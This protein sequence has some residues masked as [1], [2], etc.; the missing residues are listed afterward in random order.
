MNV[1]TNVTTFTWRLRYKATGILWLTDTKRFNIR[2]FNNRVLLRCH[3]HLFARKVLILHLLCEKS[4]AL[5]NDGELVQI[6]PK[7]LVGH[8]GCWKIWFGHKMAE[9][10][11]R[12]IE[13]HGNRFWTSC[14]HI[15]IGFE[16]HRQFTGKACHHVDTWCLQTLQT[17]FFF[18]L[19]LEALCELKTRVTLRFPLL[20]MQNLLA[21]PWL[22][23]NE[24]V[25]LVFDCTWHLNI[26]KK[27]P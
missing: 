11:K 27:K 15:C 6:P 3:F 22:F 23:L 17:L 4:G 10:Q 16:D 8:M 9:T 26:G 24:E 13:K 19:F 20:S 1:W 25:K 2:T 5:I 7:E 14:N 12:S 21:M 18:C